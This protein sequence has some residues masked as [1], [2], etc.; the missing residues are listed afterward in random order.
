MQAVVESPLLTSWPGHR[1]A[2]A[3]E[4]TGRT[5]CEFGLPAKIMAGLSRGSA[6]ITVKFV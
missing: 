4:I 2:F 6:K 3:F 5:A 1:R